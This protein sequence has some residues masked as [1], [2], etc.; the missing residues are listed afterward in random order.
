MRDWLLSCLNQLT[1][2]KCGRLNAAENKGEGLGYGVLT[3]LSPLPPVQCGM[4][5]KKNPTPGLSL[6]G[7]LPTCWLFWGLPKGLV[8][9]LSV[10]ECWQDPVYTMCTG[11][12]WEQE[13]WATCCCSRGPVVPII[14]AQTALHV[15]VHM[16]AEVGMMQL[17]TKEHQGFLRANR[18][19]EAGKDASLE[20]SE[21]IWPADP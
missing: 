12:H 16:G 6:R 19:W 20:P 10:L 4:S 8:S 15:P 21:G 17:E 3:C 2:R 9:V 1:D 5:G 18:F 11:G 14:E 7:R 13:C